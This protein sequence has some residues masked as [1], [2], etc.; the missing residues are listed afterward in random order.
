VS[1]GSIREFCF[2]ISCCQPGLH[3]PGLPGGKMARR[4]MWVAFASD[5]GGTGG[6]HISGY[7]RGRTFRSVNWSVTP[8]VVCLLA[9]DE[10]GCVAECNAR[11]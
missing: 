3:T 2:R 1:F 5:R 8:A 4:A 10:T 11:G 6:S 9:L 7:G